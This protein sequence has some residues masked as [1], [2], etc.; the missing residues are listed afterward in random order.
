MVTNRKQ[1]AL[2]DNGTRAEIVT[3]TR[4]L[5]QSWASSFNIEHAGSK[6]NIEN[7][8]SKCTQHNDQRNRKKI[9]FHST[10]HT[11]S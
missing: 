4:T 2:L 7:T 11:G 9:C 3:R 10:L 1:T 8:Q 6:I 5:V